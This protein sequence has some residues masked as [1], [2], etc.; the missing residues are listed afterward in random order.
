MVVKQPI[1]YE[2]CQRANQNPQQTLIL[3]P[4]L[5]NY[6]Q[7]E[8]ES[9]ESDGT[10][11]QKT[12]DRIILPKMIDDSRQEVKS[13]HNGVKSIKNGYLQFLPYQK[14]NGVKKCKNISACLS[15]FLW[16]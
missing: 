12:V 16:G 10:F 13:K 2:Q 3:N 14:F 7:I 15:S 6:K 5:K 9:V 4:Y 11:H 1:L 8:D